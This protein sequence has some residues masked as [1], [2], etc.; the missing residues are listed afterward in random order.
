[1][2]EPFEDEPY[3]DE[4]GRLEQ[5]RTENEIKKI[6]LS[7]EHGMNLDE[8]FANTELPP[9]VEGAFLDYI[10]EFER[11]FAEKKNI[12]VFELAD[13]PEYVPVADLP[14]EEISQHLEALTGNLSEKGISVST[15]SGV[16]DR[17]MYRF[18]T[19]ELFQ[20]ET[21]DVRIEGMM[22]GF[23]YEEFHPV[24]PYDIKNRCEEL[25]EHVIGADSNASIIPW[26]LNDTVTYGGELCSKEQ[27]NSR[28]V[29]FRDFFE[30]FSLD[31][32]SFPSVL[33]N[34]AGTQATA[35]AA[36]EYTSVVAGGE[37]LHFAGE[38]RF[39]LQN[40]HGWWLIHQFEIPGVKL[41]PAIITDTQ[42]P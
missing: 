11:Q 15:V 8:S 17:E 33:V 12:T 27:L 37:V 34:D 2:Q 42:L 25:I 38:G 16:D 35:V 22:H 36:I 5:L 6:K 14:E 10:E 1:M 39:E 41:P 31:E 4:E 7:L 28:I 29:V 21:L 9:E 20:T 18:I 32:L 23:I 30:S 26:C 19:E 24:H 40:E 13:K 3:E